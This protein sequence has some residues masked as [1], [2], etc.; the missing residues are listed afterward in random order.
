MLGISYLVILVLAFVLF[1][2]P[3]TA[4]A[5]LRVSGT[6]VSGSSD[7]DIVKIVLSDSDGQRIWEKSVSVDE[8]FEITMP[9]LEHGKYTLYIKHGAIGGEQEIVEFTYTGPAPIGNFELI[10]E[11]PEAPAEDFDSF[12]T[13]NRINNFERLMD[14]IRNSEEFERRLEVIIIKFGDERGISSQDVNAVTRFTPDG[15][16]TLEYGI[17]WTT[18]RAYN[19]IIGDARQVLELIEDGMSLDTAINFLGIIPEPDIFSIKEVKTDYEGGE[20][21]VTTG[22]VNVFTDNKVYIT[23][24]D[25]NGKIV[26]DWTTEVTP[27][28][29]YSS[30]TSTNGDGFQ[31]IGEY[32]VDV[33]YAGVTKQQKFNLLSPGAPSEPKVEEPEP[34]GF[35]KF[36]CEW[37]SKKIS[38]SEFL[39]NIQNLLNQKELSLRYLHDEKDLKDYDPNRPVPDWIRNTAFSWCDSVV[40]YDSL[41]NA[42]SYLVRE[43]NLSLEPIVTETPEPKGLGIASFVEKSKDPQSY[44]DRY[45]NEPAYKKWFDENY[46]EYDSIEQAVGL[47][48]TQKIPD[49]VKNI[50]GWYA[51]DHVSED[52]LLEAI[53]YLINEKILIVN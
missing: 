49:W 12:A 2:V 17:A 21:V 33:T 29:A 15:M 18:H 13:K 37:G 32:T 4:Y 34:E 27:R 16:E 25:P 40:A 8:T 51:A 14:F 23:L 36:V 48:L 24:F 35:K 22:T 50:F 7:G 26:Y 3:I 19:D 38:D 10:I 11:L 9:R 39:Q 6:T 1:L 43:G 45:N 5:D 53:K 30:S 44:I 52:E 28:G 20:I 47:E 42:L 41:E 46:P 31:I